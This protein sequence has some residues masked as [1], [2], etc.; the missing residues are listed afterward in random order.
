MNSQ[1]RHAYL[2]V[3]HA[4]PYVL[5]KLILMLDDI[6]NDIYIHVDIKSKDFDFDYFQ[7]LPQKSALRFVERVDVRW[8]HISL[9]KAELTLF[10]EAYQH[11]QYSYFHLISGVDLPI[12]SQDYIHAFF[13][14]NQGKEF[15]GFGDDYFDIDRVRKK[16]LFPKYMKVDGR[17]LWQRALRQIRNKGLSLQRFFNYDYRNTDG[18]NFAYGSNWVS[19]SLD[20]VKELINEEECMLD[21][22]QSAN[23]SDE[24]YKQ[25]LVLNSDFINKVYDRENELRGCMRLMDWQRGRPY[26]FRKEDFEMI[27]NSGMLFA[28]KFEDHVDTDIVDLIFDHV[29]KHQ[30]AVQG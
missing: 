19:L 15:V 29:M 17:Y 27:I 16:H 6:R 13:E 3:T 12:Q 26:T 4:N 9:V 8:G 21:F 22:Y 25:S 24:I 28:R 23:C 18:M 2:I 20:L 10:R 14:K 30:E 5:E 11:G 1:N 7:S